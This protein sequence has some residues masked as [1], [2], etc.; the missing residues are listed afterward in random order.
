MDFEN[1]QPLISCNKPRGWILNAF[2]DMFRAIQQ[3]EAP[4]AAAEAARSR[5]DCQPC[6]VPGRI[7]IISGSSRLQTGHSREE[8][9]LGQAAAK[10]GSLAGLLPAWTQGFLR[11]LRL[12]LVNVVAAESDIPSPSWWSDDALMSCDCTSWIVI[13]RTLIHKVSLF[14]HCS[15]GRSRAARTFHGLPVLF[16]L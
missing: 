11:F 6:S 16:I 7:L 4:G 2:P 1:E 14:L 12:F 15:Q 3:F 5:F 8:K 9:Q 13:T 10:G